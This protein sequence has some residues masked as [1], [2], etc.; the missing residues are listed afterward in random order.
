MKLQPSGVC[1]PNVTEYQ[2]VCEDGFSWTYNNCKTYEACDD[3]SWGSCGCIS[4]IPSDGEMCVLESELH[5]IVFL[6]EIEMD[7]SSIAVIDEM[8][9]YLQNVTFPL[10]LDELVGFLDVDITTVCNFN[11]SGYK[12]TCEDQY[13]WPC[14]K[15]REYES[16]YNLTNNTCRC[17]NDIPSDRQFCQPV[18]DI[19]N[20]TACAQPTVTPVL[21]EYLSEIQIDAEN[22]TI[23]DQLMIYW[24]SFDFPYTI[25]DSTNITETNLTTVCSLNQTQYQCKCEDLFVWPN[26]TCHSY[27]ACEDIEGSCTCLNAL[28]VNGQSCQL[29]EDIGMSMT[30]DQN[31][32]T[33]LTDPNSNDY[34]YLSAQIEK[35]INTN[36][37]KNLAGYSSGSAKVT[38]FRSGSVIADYT[39]KASSNNLDFRAAHESISDS[40]R[41][42]G[43]ILAE[44]AFALSE[45]KDFTK[46]ELY[47]LQTIDLNCIQPDFAKG[48]IQWKVNNK[49]PALDK[50]RYVISNNNSTLTVK[51]I[52]ESDSGE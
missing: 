52:S 3:I 21:I 13:F 12:C 44:D 24:M 46:D 41:A 29:K 5:F 45:Q 23:I 27:Q 6:S 8:R 30:I 39:I 40:L 2:C 50:K 19:T 43:I 37:L 28:P 48:T 1:Q 33:N 31:F 17:I 51:T 7:V 9:R 34:K 26:D 38:G 20:N 35:A 18:N 14:E 22:T 10:Q 16:C 42:E 36:Y 32:S 25:S 47:P 11:D 15:C 49:D 4:G